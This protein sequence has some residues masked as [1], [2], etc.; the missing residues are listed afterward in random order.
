M[1]GEGA[2]GFEDIGAKVPYWVLRD[3]K[4][5]GGDDTIISR[6]RNTVSVAD[7]SYIKTKQAT[8]SS[9]NAKLENGLNWS[10]AQ[11]DNKTIP[12]RAIPI[13]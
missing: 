2:I 7:I 8:N 11:S 6:K 12:H 3:A 9:T 4:N 1:L 13:N 5:N 10:L